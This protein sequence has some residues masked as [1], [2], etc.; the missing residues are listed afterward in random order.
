M[1][2]IFERFK[3][4]ARQ[5]K[6][7]LQRIKKKKKKNSDIPHIP[8]SVCSIQEK[9]INNWKQK[10]FV[11][12]ISRGTETVWNKKERRKFDISWNRIKRRKEGGG[13][14]P[15]RRRRCKGKIVS[16]YTLIANRIEFS[17]WKLALV[18]FTRR[19]N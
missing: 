11:S 10:N 13:G 14:I 18:G 4:K 19:H 16:R 12:S 8:L 2:F 9:L 1:N 5:Q 17:P 7:S 15:R 3:S 6:F